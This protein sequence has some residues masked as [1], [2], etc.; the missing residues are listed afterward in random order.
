M[1]SNHSTIAAI[2]DADIAWRR[3]RLTL[4]CRVSRPA[5][6]GANS[7]HTQGVT[8]NVAALVAVP[9]FVVTTILPVFAPLGTVAVSWVSELIVNTGALSAPNFTAVVCDRLVPVIH[10]DVPTGPLDGA[11]PEIVGTTLKVCGEAR[12]PPEI[13]RAHV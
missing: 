4:L 12:F 1:H 5:R 8:V 6:Y 13:G 3:Q 2:A 10:T 7:R 11:N 9:P